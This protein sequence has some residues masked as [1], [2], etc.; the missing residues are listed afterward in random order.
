M[1][2]KTFAKYLTQMGY[3]CEYYDIELHRKTEKYRLTVDTSEGLVR[4]VNTIVDI[5]RHIKNGGS[6][7]IVKNFDH[8][9]IE[10]V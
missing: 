3:V 10:L 4:S 7:A 6:I 8:W 2:K 5:G 1:V 9:N